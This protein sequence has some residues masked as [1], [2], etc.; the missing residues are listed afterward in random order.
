[1]L[2]TKLRMETAARTQVC[3]TCNGQG[4]VRAS[5]GLFQFVQECPRCGGSGKRIV[6]PCRRC[7]G[8]STET[9]RKRQE[10]AVPPGVSTG[11]HLKISRGGNAGPNG[12]PPGHL[13]VAFRVGSD[14]VFKREGA[15][16]YVDVR[17]TTAFPTAQKALG[18]A[19][20][21]ER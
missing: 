20:G 7:G 16:V 2:I 9:V 8:E 13:F 3:E 17:A 1:M 4:R 14:P 18:R 6:T 10:F 11:E 19:R 15:D 12:G 5:Q 21:G